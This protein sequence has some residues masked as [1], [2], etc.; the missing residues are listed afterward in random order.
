MGGGLGEGRAVEVSPTRSYTPCP[1]CG[2]EE[3]ARDRARC[4]G[5]PQVQAPSTQLPSR[6][7]RE[8]VELSILGK[9][10]VMDT[11]NLQ[12]QIPS[13]TWDN[14]QSTKMGFKMVR[15]DGNQSGMFRGAFGR[16]H[17][18]SRG[19]APL[20]SAPGVVRKVGEHNSSLQFEW[21]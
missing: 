5:R 20:P 19:T 8:L 7:L 11:K 10:R 15:F 16:C 13:S 3:S 4:L 14:T 18:W 2:C 21:L 1:T 6:V 17:C 9:P 12:H